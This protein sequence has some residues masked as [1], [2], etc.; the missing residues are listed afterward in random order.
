MPELKTVDGIKVLFIEE[1]FNVREAIIAH[2]ENEPD[3]IIV[4]GGM[5][6]LDEVLK[7]RS[8]GEYIKTEKEKPESTSLNIDKLTSMKTSQIT[9]EKFPTMAEPF[10]ERSNYGWRGEPKWY[11]KKRGKRK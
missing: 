7:G 4:G 11:D 2:K 9:I 8:L 6:G 3:L 10:I 5:N 1:G